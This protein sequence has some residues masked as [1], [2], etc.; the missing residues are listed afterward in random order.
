MAASILS[1]SYSAASDLYSTA[2]ASLNEA[3]PTLLPSPSSPMFSIYTSDF[4]NSR[5]PF[6]FDI[7][8]KYHLLPT[9]NL[10]FP[11]EDLTGWH[12]ANIFGFI[13]TVAA[14]SWMLDSHHPDVFSDVVEITSSSGSSSSTVVVRPVENTP[15]PID[16]PQV[17]LS[18]SPPTRRR[19][20]TLETI[21]TLISLEDIQARSR[22]RKLRTRLSSIAPPSTAVSTSSTTPTSPAD[23]HGQLITPPSGKSTTLLKKTS[24]REK[25][26]QRR[27]SLQDALMKRQLEEVADYDASMQLR[28]EE[29]EWRRRSGSWKTGLLLGL[30]LPIGWTMS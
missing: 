9:V 25:N 8:G 15:A 23:V 6:T 12:I 16:P 7:S 27:R 14:L 26:R 30:R 1:Q 2:I 13:F 5:L 10:P 21:A 17:Q 24:E 22:S 19:R 20:Q 18:V 28:T 3:F 4:L 11:L 29:A